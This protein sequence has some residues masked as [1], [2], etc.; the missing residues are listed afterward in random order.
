LRLQTS[1]LESLL[2]YNYYAL[3]QIT[4]NLTRGLINGA[5]SCAFG[6]DQVNR[7]QIERLP[8]DEGFRLVGQIQ[9]LLGLI[10]ID[11]LRFTDVAQGAVSLDET[12][13][14]NIPEQERYLVQSPDHIM[15]LHDSLNKASC[16]ATEPFPLLL[17]AWAWV[18]SRLPKWLLPPVL[19]SGGAKSYSEDS[20][21]LPHQRVAEVALSPQLRLFQ[22][23]QSILTGNLLWQEGEGS[24]TVEDALVYKDISRCE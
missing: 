3:A 4:A 23:W 10:C 15:S 14:A 16:V 2:L 9:Q 6:A 22:N 17:L 21:Y 24:H 12:T 11:S 20:E 7:R 5:L 18:L 1:L 19:A 8:G 13:V